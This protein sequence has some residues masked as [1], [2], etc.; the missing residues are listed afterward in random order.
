MARLVDLEP[1]GRFATKMVGAMEQKGVTLTDLAERLDASYEHCRKLAK[2]IAY[3]SKYLTK[4]I[5]KELGLDLA[6]AEEL[7]VADKFEHQFGDAGFRF[8]G[9]NPELADI[10][11]HWPSLTAD[12]KAYITTTVE[13]LAKQNRKQK[14][15]NS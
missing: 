8:M 2:G 1:Q 5:C 9:R 7:I 10:E 12:Q 6:E 3:P 14:R 15:S 4:L 11:K 13:A